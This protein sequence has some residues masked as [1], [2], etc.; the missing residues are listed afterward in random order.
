MYNK[1]NPKHFQQGDVLVKEIEALPEGVTKRNNLIL[2]E[3]EKTGHKHE[4]TCDDGVATVYEERGDL[5]VVVNGN[6][7][8]L[9][10]AEHGAMT[11]TEGTYQVGIV[12][13]FDYDAHEKRNVLD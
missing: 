2:A 3:G 13:E 7:V 8:T 9:Q 4:I 12:Q 1:K 6:S 11:L 10:H 5:F